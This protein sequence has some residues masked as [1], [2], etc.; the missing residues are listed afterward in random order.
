VARRISSAHVLKPCLQTRKRNYVYVAMEFI[1]GQKLRQWM[2]D[3][4]RPDLET[5][6]Q[7]VEQIASGLQAFHRMEM[8]HQDLRPDNVM[9][10]RTGTAKLIDFGATSVAGIAEMSM[11]REASDILGTAQYTAPEYFLGE[12]GTAR[13]DL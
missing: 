7:I 4:P 10:D 9:I 1:E 5:V 13:S 2:I 6:R 12:P 8:L 11:P 3:N